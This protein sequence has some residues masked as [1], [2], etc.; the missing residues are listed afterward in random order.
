MP[1]FLRAYNGGKLLL[2]RKMSFLVRIIV[3][4]SCR[5]AVLCGWD[6]NI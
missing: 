1:S 3:I 5:A 4:I 2:H 6:G